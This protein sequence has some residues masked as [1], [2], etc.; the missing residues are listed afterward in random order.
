MTAK[1]LRVGAVVLTYNSTEDLPACLAGLG[2]QA[3]V[4]LR[5][6]VVDNNSAPQARTQMED[7]FL[8]ACPKGQ[9]LDV[10]ALAAQTPDAAQ[11]AFFVRNTDN[12]GYSAGNNIGARLA[13]DLGC[14]AVLIVNPDVRI[15]NPTYAAHLAQ[16]IMADPKTAVACSAIQNLSGAQ[17]NPMS[18][19]DFATE[20]M[21]PI[22]MIT[23]GLRRGRAVAPPALPQG[24]TRVEKVSG[25]CLMVRC[26]FLQA[27]GFFDEVVFLYCEESILM[28][29][30][31]AAGWHMRMDAQINVLHAHRTQ[32]KGDPVR[33]F[34]AWARSRTYFHRRYSGYGP[35]RRGALV[36]SRGLTLLLVR[37]RALVA[38]LRAG[39]GT[40]TGA[41]GKAP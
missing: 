15:E 22:E 19:P 23:A 1:P 36:L 32:V 31:R 33:R 14:D 21:W 24:V 16:L 12:R 38:G 5:V 40:G 28:A 6:I 8:A 20:M 13:A 18:E 41:G 27:Q 4:D 35:L 7:D 17:E 34:V 3:D 11:R 25:A 39:T 37:L 30:V 2:A 9:V 26:D 10:G 29:Q